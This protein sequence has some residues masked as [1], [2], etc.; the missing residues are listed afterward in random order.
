MLRSD[1]CSIRGI[2][3]FVGFET[4]KSDTELYDPEGNVL[5]QMND[6]RNI[7]YQEGV[8]N[9]CVQERYS[10]LRIS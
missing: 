4:T 2:S 8:T 7:P 10:M 6:V 5:L 3:E 9:K 1:V